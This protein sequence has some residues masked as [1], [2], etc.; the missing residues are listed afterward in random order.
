MQNTVMGSPFQTAPQLFPG[1]VPMALSSQG[2]AA[3]APK[4]G[5][6]GSI[7]QNAGHLIEQTPYGSILV[8]DTGI[9][10][11]RAVSYGK[12]S[13]FESI[14]V[15][16][17]DGISL[18]LYILAVP[19]LM[20]LAAK[21]IDPLL[22]TTMLFRPG[23]AEAVNNAILKGIAQSAGTGSG[24][25]ISANAMR[26]LINGS[27]HDALGLADGWLESAMRTAPATTKGS[28]TGFIDLLRTEAYNY[29][30]TR[31]E[32][33]KNF[34][35][36]QDYLS[37]R[38]GDNYLKRITV[39][40]IDDVLSAIKN[41]QGIFA[42]ITDKRTRADLITA[43]KQAFQHT[44]GI[45]IN[46]A[47]IEKS[48]LADKN[49]PFAKILKAL[50]KTEREA[51]LARVQKMAT[52]DAQETANRML[53]RQLVLARNI[54][55]DNPALKTLLESG[56]GV[57]TWLEQAAN[58]RVPLKE[59]VDTELKALGKKLGKLSGKPQ[60]VEKLIAAHNWEAL[61]VLAKSHKE[62]FLTRAS[63]SLHLVSEPAPAT[64]L[65]SLRKYFAAVGK[66]SAAPVETLL[67]K[68]DDLLK[69]TSAPAHTQEALAH[70]RSEI[71]KLLSGK[72]GRITSL[73][74]SDAV[75]LLSG[76]VQELMRG[77]LKHDDVLFKQTLA[78]TNELVEDSRL[79]SNPK[80]LDQART[81]YQKYLKRLLST[82]EQEAGKTG[83][84]LG[85]SVLEKLMTAQSKLNQNV[86]MLSR[87][88]ALGVAM[89][90]IGWGVPKIQYAITKKLT[91]KNE[92]PTFAALN[93]EGEAEE[94]LVPQFNPSLFNGP[95]LN[96]NNAF[97]LFQQ[98]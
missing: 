54:A 28:R 9:T 69:T 62:S 42:E 82:T 97:S 35:R 13:P 4:F 48:L 91:G 90:A 8:V 32:G 31:D 41:K 46:M 98:R 15:V 70:Y 24:A 76:K 77:G 26:T 66:D 58:N 34:G 7:I 92:H 53:R 47:N 21:G 39:D 61:E 6:I 79:Y 30:S 87:V 63:R 44:A 89:A 37:A 49:S 60:E 43:V 83:G 38:M 88:A 86:H 10:G 19:H 85:R 40:D 22:K 50:P 57:A 36:V 16:V 12:R 80:K 3:A 96:R 27:S 25:E 93:K 18:Y 65:E 84:K 72:E 23:A 59:M 74:I 33:I 52:L 64:Q 81:L 67:G 11:G 55:G 29:A 71:T 75:E 73:H 56:E 20:A 2:Q 51:L 68:L 14:E 78:A 95:P 45:D 5:G 94:E 1:G 17:R